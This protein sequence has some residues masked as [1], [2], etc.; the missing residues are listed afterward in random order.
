MKIFTGA[1]I[2]CLV[3]YTGTVILGI[4]TGIWWPLFFIVALHFVEF[5]VIGKK[6]GDAVG[7]PVLSAFIVC[8]LFGFTWWLPLRKQLKKKG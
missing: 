8:M 5:F 2:G 1:K 3:I 7:M 6:T 4:V